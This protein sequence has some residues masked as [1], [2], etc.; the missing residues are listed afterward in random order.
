MVNRY[1]TPIS[2]AKYLQLRTTRK[3][4]NSKP[5]IKSNE[6][7]PL[8]RKSG[9]IMNFIPAVCS[10]AYIPKKNTAFKAFFGTRSR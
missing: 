8:V 6:L 10:A 7:T 1:L 3:F 2:A 4:P 9:S 5:T